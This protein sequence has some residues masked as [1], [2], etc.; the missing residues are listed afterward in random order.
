[1]P[2]N[3]SSG[4]S[5]SRPVWYFD[6][7][8]PF[9]YLQFEWMR[10]EM[11]DLDFEPRPVLL[12]ALLKHWGSIGPAE[13]PIKRLFTY[14]FVTWKARQLGIP[15]RFPPTHPFNPLPALRL[16]I[17]AGGGMDAIAAVFRHLW[18]DGRDGTSAD[19]LSDLAATLGVADVDSAIADVAVKSTLAAS[20]QSA[21]ADGVFGV[22]TFV[23]DGHLFWGLDATAML[24][25]YL[26]QPGAFQDEAMRSLA[27]LPV[28]IERVR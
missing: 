4:L 12:A 10:R 7:I 24:V 14:R 1:M 22:P 8:S 9:A 20:G 11:P 3:S 6:F 26:A 28:G 13:Q 18:R 19:A 15:M 17:A 5:S 23:H 2:I 16:A 25:D 27:T 21:L